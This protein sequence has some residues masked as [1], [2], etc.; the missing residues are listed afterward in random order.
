MSG[1]Q[2]LDKVV[3]GQQVDNI[4]RFLISQSID[5]SESAGAYS[6]IDSEGIT[7]ASGVAD[8][9]TSIPMP[10]GQQSVQVRA[11]FIVPD[12]PTSNAGER[13]QLKWI[14]SVPDRTW[15]SIEYLTIYAP[16]LSKL[17]AEDSVELE[18]GN[19]KLTACFESTDLAGLV[20]YHNNTQIYAAYDIHGVPT[21]EGQT[22]THQFVPSMYGLI[23]DLRPYTVIWEYQGILGVDREMA[24]LWI[25]NPMILS[26]AKQLH[27]TL[28]RLQREYRLPELE[29]TMADMLRFLEMGKDRFNAVGIISDI[30]MIMAENAFRHWWLLCSE[31]A[32]L[33]SRYL[34]E[35]E[36]SFDFS[37]QA[38]SL[39][40]DLTSIIDGLIGQLESQVDGQLIPFKQQLGSKG[41]TTGNGQWSIGN[42]VAGAMGLSQ[43]VLARPGIQSVRN[44]FL[45]RT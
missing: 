32:A 30:S 37:G 1:F 3:V 6:I 34:E 7:Y 5:I 41:L 24:Q 16:T 29:F 45:V 19:A 22:Y 4:S 14:L 38:V 43:S 13:Y 28:N 31:I 9:I 26:A 27:Q 39:S 12:V 25:V 8:N 10:S 11:Q 2:T 33:R 21:F 40:F 36:S 44:L 15:T 20:I 42:Q 18:F 17:G 35:G 23:A